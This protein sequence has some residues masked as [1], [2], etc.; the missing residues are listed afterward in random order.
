MG[1]IFLLGFQD[2]TAIPA[3]FPEWDSYSCEVSVMGKIYPR[4][5]QDGMDI[6]SW[7]P[8]WDIFL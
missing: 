1:C 7:F 4:G 2:G 6:S 5:F 3:R 8:G